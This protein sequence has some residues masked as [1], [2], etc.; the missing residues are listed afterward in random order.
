MPDPQ[1]VYANVFWTGMGTFVIVAA[2][3]ALF[4][5]LASW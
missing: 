1:R 2:V 4:I 5:W 3:L